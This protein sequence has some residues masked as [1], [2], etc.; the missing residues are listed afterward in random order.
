MYL[1]LNDT[2][3]QSVLTDWQATL[4]LVPVF[5]DDVPQITFPLTP[6]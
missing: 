3:V 2:R 5:F 1:I 4:K 6:L